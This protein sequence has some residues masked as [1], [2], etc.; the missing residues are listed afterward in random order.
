VRGRLVDGALYAERIK[1]YAPGEAE[2]P[3]IRGTLEAVQ[4]DQMTL[5][6]FVL[7]L[8]AETELKGAPKDSKKRVL[9]R[10]EIASLLDAG[11]TTYAAAHRYV[12]ERQLYDLRADP[13]ELSPLPAEAGAPFENE[14]DELGKALAQKRNFGAGDQKALDAAAVKALQDIGY[15]GGD[16]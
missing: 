1:F 3:E 12:L 16:H 4:Q 10:T 9:T 14:L 2:T 8:T 13:A 15:G 5:G 6:G 11:A 7:A